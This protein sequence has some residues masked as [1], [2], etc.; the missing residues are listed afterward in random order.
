MSILPTGQINTNTPGFTGPAYDFAD[1]LPL[2]GAVGVHRGNNMDD[3]I[4]AVKGAGYY[5]DMIGFGQSSTSLT[6]GM[7]GLRPLG[8]NYFIKTGLQCDNG[9]DM[10]YYVNGVP[11]GDALGPK[12]KAGLASAGLPGLRGLAPGMMEDAK[13]ALNPVPVMNA[14]LGSGYPKCRKVTLPVGDTQGKT[15]ASDGTPWIVGPIDRSTGQ[16]MQTQW[17]QDINAKG[18]P[19]FLTQSEFNAAAKNF[20]PDGTAVKAHRSGDCTK[21]TVNEGF[22]SGLDMEGLFMTGLLC[23]AAVFAVARCR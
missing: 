11:T 22:S 3:V 17:V 9:A 14:I 2:P 8:V 18:S 15:A 1:E 20:C 5:V 13:D 21:P 6:N 12:V 4:G 16:P 19:I 23:A 10:W 7:G